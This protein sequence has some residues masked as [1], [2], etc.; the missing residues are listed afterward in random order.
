[1]ALAGKR[2]ESE[3]GGR[4]REGVDEDVRNRRGSFSGSGGIII[5]G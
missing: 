5:V 4:R 3:S 2:A 1:M